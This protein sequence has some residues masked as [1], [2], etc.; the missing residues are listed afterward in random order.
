MEGETNAYIQRMQSLK[1][2]LKE[3][4]SKFELIE[5]EK[6]K[7]QRKLKHKEYVCH[8]LSLCH[9]HTNILGTCYVMCRA[10]EHTVYNVTV[11]ITV[12]LIFVCSKQVDSG[13][14]TYI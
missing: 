9:R 10:I 4:A 3:Q 11:I 12:P 6:D 14:Y 5:Q 2:Q 1:E 8:T 7:K 13:L